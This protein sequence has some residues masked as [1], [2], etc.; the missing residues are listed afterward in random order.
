MKLGKPIKPVCLGVGG[1]LGVGAVVTLKPG[2]G[3]CGQFSP[4]LGSPVRYHIVSF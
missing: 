2:L 3:D 4:V 1:A